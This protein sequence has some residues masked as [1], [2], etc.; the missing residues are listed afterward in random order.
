MAYYI[1]VDCGTQGT[2]VVVYDPE[3]RTF[4]GDGYAGH[5]ILSN[6]RGSREQEPGWWIDALDCAMKNAL[7][8]LSAD[9]R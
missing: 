5:E 2:K 6:E 4:L 7:K 8:N 3:T 1:G 9:E